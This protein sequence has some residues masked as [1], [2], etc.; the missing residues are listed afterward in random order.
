MI[1][2]LEKINSLIIELEGK[3]R[4]NESLKKELAIDKKSLLE[5]EDVLS[6]RLSGVKLLEN[7]YKEYAALDI[8]KQEL[9]IKKVD[10][11]K[12]EIELNK[13]SQEN[14]DTLKVIEKEK[15]SIKASREVFKKQAVILKEKEQNIISE[16]KKIQD[17]INGK[18]FK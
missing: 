9:S 7:K 4:I 10:L 14:I 11:G 1:E 3:V 12:L 18:V 16:K 17:I 13:K 2:T 8:V 15:D 5:K 6:K